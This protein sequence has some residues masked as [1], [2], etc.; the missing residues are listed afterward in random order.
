MDDVPATTRPATGTAPAPAPAPGVAP[1][2]RRRATALVLGL[3][4]LVLALAAAC[5]LSLAVGAGGA[6]PGAALRALVSPDRTDHAQ[7]VVLESRLPR[8]VAGVLAGVALGLAGAVM[9]G[10]TRNPLAD[11]GLLGVNAGAAAGV[12]VALG[13]LGLTRPSQYLW[14]GFVGAAGA[15]ALVYA[16]GSAGAGGAS[17]VKLALAGAATGSALTSATTVV[18][19]RDTATYDRFRFWQVGSLTARDPDVVLHA[20]PFLV[21]GA[22]LA[23][24]AATGLDALALGDDTATSLGVRVSRTRAL[25]A[26]CVVL[27]C[28]GATVVAGPVAF[29]GLVAPH[30]ARRAT[31]PSHRWLLPYSALV[32]PVVLLVADV[33]GRVV[34]PP[35]EVEAG[36]VVAVVGAVPFVLLVRRARLAAA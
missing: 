6:T 27:L 3:V 16:L 34:A 7:L 25:C 17:P 5:L 14:A 4:L 24:A 23:A 33:L 11:P 26:T 2:R 15:S 36:V 35:G 9:Q 10:L 12:V 32:A 20:V 21:V 30:V 22:L 8:T 31:G 1:A 28:G 29:L 13:V 18:L 19:L